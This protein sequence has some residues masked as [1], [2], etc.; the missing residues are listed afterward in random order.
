[1]TAAERPQ[2]HHNPTR[3]DSGMPRAHT[4]HVSSLPTVA[5]VSFSALNRPQSVS[6]ASPCFLEFCVS[7]RKTTWARIC[8]KSRRTSHCA[9][10]L[11]TFQDA[12]HKSSL[13]FHPLH[14][15]TTLTG[16][17]FI[18]LPLRHRM[19][20]SSF[21]THQNPITSERPSTNYNHR[22]LCFF[23]FPSTDFLALRTS[24]NDSCPDVSVSILRPLHSFLFSRCHHLQAVEGSVHRSPSS[25]VLSFP[26]LV[27]SSIVPEKMLPAKASS[28]HPSFGLNCHF[29][30]VFLSPSSCQQLPSSSSFQFRIS[31]MLLPCHQFLLKCQPRIDIFCNCP[32]ELF[33]ALLHEFLTTPRSHNS[34]QLPRFFALYLHQTDENAHVVKSSNCYLTKRVICSSMTGSELA[35]VITLPH[36]Q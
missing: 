34:C 9:K 17:R 11:S 13:V 35:Y 8:S 30:A 23:Y 5:F 12:T 24:S 26:S 10:V 1:M 3:P 16:L 31:R 6:S 29:H 36:W 19:P 2:H 18:L 21:V 32:S 22:I 4:A 20:P 27:L 33:L 15:S 7:W 25:F 28:S 14:M